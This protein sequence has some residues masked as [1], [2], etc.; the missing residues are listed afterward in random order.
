VQSVYAA[1]LDVDGDIDAASITADGEVA[2]YENTDGL[3]TFGSAQIIS[4]EADNG[5]GIFAA[6]L[7]GDGDNDV[8]SASITGDKIAWYENLTILSV[9][10]STLKAT[11]LYPNPT[12]ESFQIETEASVTAIQVY[13]ALGQEVQVTIE[14]NTSVSVAMRSV[15]IYTVVVTG[16]D[17]ALFSEKIVKE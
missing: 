2:W 13:N 3:G 1:D 12:S 6:D 14:N 11:I 8:L 4:L 10:E 16:G 17:G 5:R 7:D 15:G 9:P